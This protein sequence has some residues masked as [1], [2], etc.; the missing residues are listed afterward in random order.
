MPGP[1]RQPAAAAMPTRNA[2]LLTCRGRNAADGDARDRPRAQPAAVRFSRA[3]RQAGDR[4]AIARE[5]GP[6]GRHLQQPGPARV[7]SRARPRAECSTRT[8]LHQQPEKGIY[9]LHHAQL[10]RSAHLAAQPLV[11]RPDLQDGVG[12]VGPGGHGPADVVSAQAEA[13]HRGDGVKLEAGGQRAA[14][15]VVVQVW[16]KGQRQQAVSGGSWGASTALQECSPGSVH[17]LQKMRLGSSANSLGIVP[18]SWL[19]R[20]S[21]L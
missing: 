19:L 18:V 6:A 15:P 14:E 3:G 17:S 4:I 12:E 10:P 8:P 7:G 21:M 1:V 2:P 13:H 20:Q 16:G 11:A 9:T 5:L